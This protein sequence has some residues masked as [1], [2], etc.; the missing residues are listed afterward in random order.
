MS[1]R[2][3]TPARRNSSPAPVAIEAPPTLPTLVAESTAADHVI[4]LVLL[5]RRS[6]GKTSFFRRCIV[7]NAPSPRRDEP[8]PG[9]DKK[10]Y[11]YVLPN[12]KRILINMW[13]CQAEMMKLGSAEMRTYMRD[14]QAA[15]VL[16]DDSEMSSLEVAETYT[17]EVK[18]AS[19][20]FVMLFFNIRF[21]KMVSDMQFFGENLMRRHGVLFHAGNI[22]TKHDSAQIAFNDFLGLLFYVGLSSIHQKIISDLDIIKKLIVPAGYAVTRST[23][24]TQHNGAIYLATQA[25]DTPDSAGGSSS[26]RESSFRRLRPA[27]VAADE[28]DED[29]SEPGPLKRCMYGLFCCYWCCTPKEEQE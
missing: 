11:L 9:I 1:D 12:H 6:S 15:V 29:D 7:P 8:T 27:S 22:D 19:I 21:N 18:Q 26:R 16:Y 14:A 25:P 13:D 20:Q 10:S 3:L 5:G 24:A 28:D 17:K 4:K 23:A 2:N